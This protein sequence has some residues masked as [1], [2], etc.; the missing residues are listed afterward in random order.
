MH[1]NNCLYCEKA[2]ENMKGYY[3]IVVN[4]PKDDIYPTPLKIES[5]DHSIEIELMPG[6]VYIAQTD[7]PLQIFASFS[8]KTNSAPYYATINPNEFCHIEIDYEYSM[9]KNRY[10]VDKIIFKTIKHNK[11]YVY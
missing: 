6:A 8:K 1:T 5:F 2:F 9:Y 7:K 3:M 10:V 4:K 11:E